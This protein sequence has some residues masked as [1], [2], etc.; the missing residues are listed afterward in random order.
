MKQKLHLEF[1]VPVPKIGTGKFKNRLAV[2]NTIPTWYR[3][4]KTKIKNTFKENLSQWHIEES[5]LALEEN[6]T[7]E[8]QLYRP[9]K[10]KLDA[11]SI[12]I[13]AGKWT[14]D[15]L[16]EKGWIK[17]DNVVTFIYRP[18]IVEKERVETEVNVKVYG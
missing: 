18:V 4:Q 5:Q 7:V 11:D 3:F 13:S 12:A 1:T 8:F 6:V 15:L 17:D 9:T 10:H 14:V 2:N 16:V